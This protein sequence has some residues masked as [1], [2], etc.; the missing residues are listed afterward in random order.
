MLMRCLSAVT[1]PLVVLM[2]IGCFYT[3][4][5]SALSITL[6]EMSSDGTPAS[7]LDAVLDFTIVNGN[8]LQIVVSN[9][10]SGSDEFNI[11][12]VFWSGGEDVLSLTLITAEH[13]IVG[14]VFTSW[15]PVEF[16]SMVDGFG[17][18]DFGL[19]DGVG[20][21]ADDVIQPGTNI[22]FLLNI[23]GACAVAQDC[24]ALADFLSQAST[25]SKSVAAKFVNGPADP[26]DPLEEDSAWGASAP[27]P[28]PGTLALCVL[29]LSA[30]AAATRRQAV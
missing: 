10:T 26:E 13:S 8:Q 4:S 25:N 27:I 23:S 2:V 20:A 15:S 7:T 19:T 1:R 5:A 22:T 21:N 28:E 6:S 16:D 12:Q 3:H 29:G 11:N 18:F 17:V 30:L 9:N 14:D 24:D